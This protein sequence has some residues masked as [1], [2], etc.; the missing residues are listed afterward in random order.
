MIRLTSDKGIKTLQIQL[1][2]QANIEIAIGIVLI[3]KK[4][5]TYQ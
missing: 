2:K 3:S 1:L 4:I 5:L